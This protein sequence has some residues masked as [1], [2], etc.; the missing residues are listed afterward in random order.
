MNVIIKTGKQLIG[1]YGE[2]RGI[3]CPECGTRQYPQVKANA[4]EHPI[5][6]C[7]SCQSSYRVPYGYY[8]RITAYR[9]E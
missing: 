2:C 4:Y 3:S 8:P 1:S 6:I 7:D 9:Y 5:V